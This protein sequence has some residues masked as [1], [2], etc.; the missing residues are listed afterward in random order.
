MAEKVIK[1]DHFDWRLPFYAAVVALIV[2]LP[3]ATFGFNLGILLYIFVVIPII[4][5]IWLVIAI[6]L[7]CW[8]NRL[9]SLAI[10]SM[11]AV[12]C[13][14][15]WGL[16]KNSLELHTEARWVLLSNKYKPEVLA[17]PE[18][19][20]GELKH[21]EWD[22]WGW[23]GSDTTAY[24]VFDPDNSLSSATRSHS[25]G[26][27]SGIPCGVSSVQRLQ[28]H[29]YS[30]VFYTDTGWNDCGPAGSN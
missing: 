27:F 4:S 10:L 28:S 20:N 25:S 21:V 22:G 11:L 15:S 3:I 24:L 14:V 19:K 17:Q 18:P 16:F 5:L 26:K 29:W 12:Y 23:G 7:A 13:A 6:V 9:L 2:F 1:N 30:V 8:R